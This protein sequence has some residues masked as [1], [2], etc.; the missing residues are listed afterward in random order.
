MLRILRSLSPALAVA[1]LAAPAAAHAAP[2]VKKAGAATSKKASTK[3]SAK[4]KKKTVKAV[5][6][7]VNSISPRKI[8][9]G[10]KLTVKG[11]GFKPGKGKS[12]VA[13]YKTGQPVIFVKADSATATK[14]VVTITPKVAAL[15]V[16]KNDV[17]VATLLRLRV[18]GTKMSRTWTK[19]SRSPIVSPLPNAPV[20]QGGSLT[21]Q[22]AAAQVYQSCQDNA[23]TNPAGDNDADN[24]DNA[25]ELANSM[26]PCNVDTDGDGIS[27]GYEYRS[28]EDLNG[29][30]A[31]HYP[32]TRP[33]PNPLD[34]TDINSDFDGDGLMMWQ[35][36]K[37]W[38]AATGGAFPL[39]A[40]SDG[41]QNSGGKVPV[42]EAT[43]W[44]DLDG[45]GN[46]TDDERDEDN[47][48]LS[49]FVEFNSTGTQAWWKSVQWDVK[50]HVGIARY[51]ERPYTARLFNDVDASNPDTDGD[52]I[53]DGADDQ[54][55]DGW[56]NF[57]EMQLDR[58]EVGYRVNPYN[59][60]LPNPHA[61]VCSRHVPMDP[62]QRWAPWDAVNDTTTS[63]MPEDAIPFS[64]PAQINYSN[65]STASPNP[66]PAPATLP[67]LN[68]PWNTPGTWYGGSAYQGDLDAIHD[69]YVAAAD[70]ADPAAVRAA[71][72]AGWVAA[73][74]KLPGFSSDP[75]YPDP[76]PNVWQP[77][78]FGSW[79]PAPWFTSAWG[80]AMAGGE[81]G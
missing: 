41:T 5:Y 75:R 42:T 37:L 52:G 17:P 43:K 61:S 8:Q 62:S 27:D 24:I 66:S 30:S 16:V 21:A 57:V 48:G 53:P 81:Q 25:T 60:C 70:P 6:P 3:K 51:T 77:I 72:A 4:T 45:D 65:W 71:D 31:P 12:S 56:P 39:T 55:N 76:Y 14:L 44:L 64:W 33:W 68:T 47:D 40:Y 73:L 22:Q 9:I 58:D 7:T 1:V 15:L 80:N 49:N 18:I 2:V 74:A 36:N 35:E 38:K 28:A 20:G 19:N 13:F 11:T 34:P 32:S 26:D 79:D 54:D 46:L 67:P 63:Q 50:P 29:H 23:K 59:P 69:P 78:A 10:Q